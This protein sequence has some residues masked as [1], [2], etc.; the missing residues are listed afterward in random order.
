MKRI[1][2]TCRSKYVREDTNLGI[3]T[4]ATERKTLHPPPFYLQPPYGTISSK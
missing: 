1:H 3:W 4:K 2:K